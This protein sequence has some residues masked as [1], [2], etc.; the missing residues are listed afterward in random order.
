MAN[1]EGVGVQVCKIINNNTNKEKIVYVSD[2]EGIENSFNEYKCQPYETIQQIPYGSK[3]GRMILYV[4]APSGAGK[5]YFVNIF[6]KNYQKIYKKRQV[7]L[8]SY[9]ENDVSITAKNIKR[10][11]LDNTFVS[12]PLTLEDFQDSL[13]IYDDTD[14]VKNREIKNKLSNI[15]DGLL[16]GGRHHNTDVIYTSHLCNKGHETRLILAEAH[17]IVLF[18]KVMGNRALSYVLDQYYGLSKKQISKIKKL[19]GRW[20]SL[21]KTHPY[22]ILYK[23]GLYILN[24]EDD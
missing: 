10:I 23:K 21:V 9:F 2:K 18:P 17:S 11:K 24:V 22:V 13:I 15:L 4:T 16:Q 7:Y 12:T 3:K 5:S 6:I 8:F 1:F 19:S 14:F 20:I